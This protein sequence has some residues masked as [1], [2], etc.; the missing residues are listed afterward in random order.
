MKDEYFEVLN[1]LEQHH[2]LFGRFWTVGNIVESEKIPTASISFDRKSG[3]GLQFM[4]NPSFWNSIDLYKKVFVIAHECL[5]VYLEHGK[6]MVGFNPKAANIAADI[7]VN[8]YL[9]DGFGFDRDRIDNWEQYCWLDTVFPDEDVPAGQSFEHYYHLIMSKFVNQDEGD[10]DP[11]DQNP[12]DG[13]GSGL[14][15]Q[16]TVDNHEG[17]DGLDESTME[18]IAKKL[19]QKEI[20]SFQEITNTHNGK[21]CSQASRDA[22][23]TAGTLSQIIKL[24]KIVKK[25]KWETVIKNVIGR[26]NA[27]TETI[28]EQWAK[29]NRRMTGLQSSELMLPSEVDEIADCKDKVDVWLFQDTSGSCVNYA[30]RFFKA[31]ASIPE[32]RFRVRMFCF[33]TRVYETSI[34]TG[35]LYGFG[36][37]SFSC[38]ENYIDHLVTTEPG[39][40]YP[41]VVFI[42]TDGYGDSVSPKHPERWHWFLTDDYSTKR[43]VPPKSKTY[44]L[45]DFE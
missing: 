29:Q 25:R 1:Q 23:S 15:N 36:G 18:E 35:K 20:E 9:V 43:Y 39:C 22:G 41:S 45:E 14:P 40:A 2:A 32:D 27:E 31:A 21:E 34:K 30:E 28:I 12:G 3:D 11:N 6:R 7:V 16:Q 5:H 19:S 37:T 26:F 24:N 44:N 13:S 8:H 17:L 33:D 42:V 10:G 38:I 4:I